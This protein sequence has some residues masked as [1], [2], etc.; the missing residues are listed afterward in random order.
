MLRLRHRW[1]L[2]VPVALQ[3]FGLPLRAD[4]PAEEKRVIITEVKTDSKDDDRPARPKTVTLEAKSGENGVITIVR[5]SDSEKKDDGKKEG[6]VEE[7]KATVRATVRVKSADGKTFEI[8][9]P[10]GM[11]KIHERILE[12][13]GK[14]L[15]AEIREGNVMIFRSS[16]GETKTIESGDVKAL[17]GELTARIREGHPLEAPKFVIGVSV[18]EAPQVVLAQIGKPE[19]KA[20]VV[21][22]VIDESPAAKAGVQKYDLILKAGEL[23]VSSPGELTKAVKDSEGKEIKLIVVRTGKEM[24]VSLTPKSNDAKPVEV[25]AVD[26]VINIGPG[27]KWGQSVPAFPGGASAF[28]IAGSPK[29]LEEIQAL[30]K[31]IEELKKMVSEL[32]K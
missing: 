28:A 7:K 1:L 8:V 4:E 16:N 22:S 21:E 27:I 25:K 12:V 17:M 24:T 30:R 23:D 19:A 5:S 9:S 31:E 20:V 18:A 29:V 14:Q 26:G 13:Q 2:A 32:K 15:P 10:E 6:A 11:E 3:S